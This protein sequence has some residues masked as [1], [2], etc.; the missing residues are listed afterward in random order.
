MKAKFNTEPVK[1]WGFMRRREIEETRRELQ[2][3]QVG[4]NLKMNRQLGGF[5]VLEDSPRSP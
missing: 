5:E 3:G 1:N 4:S 2:L